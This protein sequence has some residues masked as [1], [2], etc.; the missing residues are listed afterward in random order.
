V[1]SFVF[2][3]WLEGE[4]GAVDM[5]GSSVLLVEEMHHVEAGPDHDDHK[6]HIANNHYT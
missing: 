6:E 2:R 5:Q 3:R 1:G 4:T